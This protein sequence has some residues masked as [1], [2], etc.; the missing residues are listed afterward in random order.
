MANHVES[1]RD[2]IQVIGID[3]NQ[4]FNFIQEL[5]V[6]TKEKAK[7]LKIKISRKPQFIWQLNQERDMSKINRKKQ[8]KNSI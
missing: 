5:Q 8:F 3:Q 7:I 1:H 4:D 6:S 2:H